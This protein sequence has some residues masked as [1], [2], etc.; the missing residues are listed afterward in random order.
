MNFRIPALLL[1]LAV[2]SFAQTFRG[3]I[4]GT[5]LD[6]SGA[7]IPNAAVTLQNVVS[8]YNQSLR[9]DSAGAFRIANVPVN[10]YHLEVSAPG[11]TGVGTIC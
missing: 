10:S 2:A 11:P 3:A 8:G 9:A 7:G 1:C 5:V 4:E 6:P